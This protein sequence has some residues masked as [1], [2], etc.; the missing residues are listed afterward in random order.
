MLL[1]LLLL[2][3]ALVLFWWCAFPYLDDFF[4]FATVIALWSLGYAVY[5]NFDSLFGPHL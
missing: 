5:G 4:R 2:V 1:L 3:L